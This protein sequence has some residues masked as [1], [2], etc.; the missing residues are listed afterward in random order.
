MR[1]KDETVLKAMATEQ[2]MLEEAIQKSCFDAIT[3]GRHGRNAEKKTPGAMFDMNKNSCFGWVPD[4]A[5]M[6]WLKEKW[7]VPLTEQMFWNL[8]LHTKND[9]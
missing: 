3:H 1:L 6:E 9:K 2:T 8:I 7:G 5:I 4:G